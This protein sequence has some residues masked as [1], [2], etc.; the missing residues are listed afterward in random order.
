MFKTLKYSASLLVLSVAPS[1]ADFDDVGTDY[2]NAAVDKWSEDSINDYVS[3]AN[4]FACILKN[5]RPDALP[6]ATYEA[7]ISEVQC[8]LKD[9]VVNA[10]GVSNRATLSS[11]TMINS[12]ASATANQEGQFWFNSQTGQK[13][14]GGITMKKSPTDLPPYGAWGLSFYLNQMPEMPP[15]VTEFTSGVSGTSPMKGYVDISDTAIGNTRIM[16]MATKRQKSFTQTL[17]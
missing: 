14:I 10:S 5:A 16:T 6:N 8:G 15:G 2:S 3:M 11:S 4:S 7:L 17:P 9:E 1:L 13:F 12:R